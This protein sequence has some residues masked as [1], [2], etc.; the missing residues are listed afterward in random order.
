MPFGVDLLLP[1]VGGNARKTNYDYTKGSLPELIDV[2]IDEGAKLFV[3]AVGVPPKW[4]VEKLHKAGILY[5]NVVGHPKHV[6]KALESGS[7]G[8]IA[9]GGEAGGHTGEI[10]SSVLFPRVVDLCRGKKSP[11]TGKPLITLVGGG[12]FDGRGLASAIAHGADGVW[13]GTRFV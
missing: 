9:Q 7:D 13:V 2:I 3:C 10:P 1:Q 6:A 5:M 8:I 4:A 12:I 11:L